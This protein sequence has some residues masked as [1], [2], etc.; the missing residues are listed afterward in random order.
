MALSN[1]ALSEADVGD[2]NSAKDEQDRNA[3]Q[4]EEP[5]KDGTTVVSKP[6]YS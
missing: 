6:A 4:S 2:S 5:V 3:R 1:P